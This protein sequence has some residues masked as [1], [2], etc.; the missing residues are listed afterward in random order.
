MFSA[1]LAYINMV[2]LPKNPCK[3]NCF[4]HVAIVFRSDFGGLGEPTI[5]LL[6]KSTNISAILQRMSV[7][8]TSLEN[9]RVHLQNNT[10]ILRNVVENL[11]DMDYQKS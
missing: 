5:K 7:W 11:C 1:G 6:Q 8:F 9:S 4:P 10:Y 2:Y 3:G